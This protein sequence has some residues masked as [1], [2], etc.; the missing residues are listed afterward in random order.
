MT[1]ARGR[2]PRPGVRLIAA[3]LLLVAALA[4]FF[5]WRYAAN[6]EDTVP[7][8]P[9]LIVL[10]LH[11]AGVRHE[12]GVLADGL[13]AELRDEFARVK[14]LLT[15]ANATAL[16][17]GT[18]HLYPAQLAQRIGVTR[19]LDGELRELG[20]EQLH[21]DLRLRDAPGGR[22]L[23]SQ[24]YD[25]RLGDI[26]ALEDDIVQAVAGQL[27]MSVRPAVASPAVD[28][29]VFRDYL[30]A[31][32]LI[33]GPQRARGIDMLREIVKNAPNHARAHAALARTLTGTLRGSGGGTRTDLAD[34]TIASR[35][36]LDL[37]ADLADAHAAQAVLACRVSDWSRCMDS[38]AHALALDPGDT[39]CRITYAYWLSA[40]GYVDRALAEARTA[41][42]TD[43]LN[44]NVNF[45]LARML[46]TVGRHDEAAQILAE[47]GTESGGLVYA[48]WH[49][50]VWRHD[51][52]AAAT[53]VA[54]MPRS[55]GFRESYTVVT[56]AL[57][58]PRLWA[59]AL[60]LIGTSERASGGINVQRVMMPNPD[61]AIVIVGL[62]KM[63]HDGWP[64]YYMLLWM[65]EYAAL[66]R[67][68]AFQDFLKR[69]GLLDY[70]RARGFPAQCRADGDGAHCD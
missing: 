28:T 64:S 67:T 12:E 17:A 58:E 44:Y 39:E 63:L 26:A 41:R 5:A 37:Q 55:D 33:D 59:Q 34:A 16:R 14:G 42:R 21:V 25:R 29:S 18:E 23:W 24:A 2:A 6:T 52:A 69:G 3:V 35:T 20:G 30:E 50:A 11:P 51:Y 66:R 57:S 31:R 38:F 53:L 46:D 36:A 70:W 8:A 43:P 49:N 54:A 40:L 1:H 56:E 7:G 47:L 48:R 22:V 60:P 45:A 27:H 13:S 9:T 32:Q 65:P 68:P 62:E 4:A 61:Y 15:I 19:V 10:P